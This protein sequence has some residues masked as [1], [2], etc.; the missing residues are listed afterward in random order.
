[1]HHV[2]YKSAPQYLSDFVQSVATASCNRR[3]G[4]RSADTANYVKRCTRTKFGERAFSFAG[5]AAYLRTC[6]TALSQM[7]LRN[8]SR[9]FCSNVHSSQIDFILVF[10]YFSIVSASGHFCIAALY[11]FSVYCI[12]L[13]CSGLASYSLRRTLGVIRSR[14]GSFIPA[15]WDKIWGSGHFLGRRAVKQHHL[16]NIPHILSKRTCVYCL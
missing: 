11:K 5:P 3:A 14:L 10:M 16:C 2:H 15:E 12:V 7:Y 8:D 4:L 1:M 13:Y 6:S 9:H